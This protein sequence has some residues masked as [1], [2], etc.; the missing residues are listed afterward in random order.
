ML[1]H[2]TPDEDGYLPTPYEL[3]APAELTA[4]LEGLGFVNSKEFRKRGN[5]VA[6]SAQDYLTM[7]LNG[8]PLGHSLSE[9]SKEVQDGVLKKSRANIE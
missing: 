5:F 7:F 8:S 1:E 9:E 3:G 2:A 4:M 6:E